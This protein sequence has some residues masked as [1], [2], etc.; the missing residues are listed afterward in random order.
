MSSRL[1]KSRISRPRTALAAARSKAASLWPARKGPNL[2]GISLQTRKVPPF[3]PAQA[4][5]SLGDIDVGKAILRGSFTFGGQTLD[6]GSQGNPWVTAAPSRRHAAW[7]HGFSWLPD[8]L[9]VKGETAENYAA[10]LVDGWIVTYGKGN[11]FA[12][13]LGQ[14][15]PRCY[16]WGAFWSPSLASVGSDSALSARRAAMAQHLSALRTEYRKLEPGLPR[17]QGACALAMGAARSA[18]GGPAPLSRALDRLDL[19]IDAQILPDGG[20]V[21]RSPMAA[22]QALEWLLTLDQ[23]LAA[24]GVEN[25]RTVSRAIDRIA[26]MICV[27]RRADGTLAPFN[28]GG[29]LESDDVS[30]LMDAAPGVPKAFGY[31]PHS[32]FQRL[33]AGESVLLID[34]GS[35]PPRPFD[36]EAHLAPLSIDLSTTDGPIITSCGWTD[37]MPPAWRRPVRSAAAHS[38]LTLDERSPGRL[39][40]P[41]WMRRVVGD[42]VDLDSGPAQAS[43]KEQVS[44]I[45]IEASHGGYRPEYGLAHRRRLFMPANGDDIRGEDCLYVPIGE[46]PIRRDEVDFALRFH[47]HPSVQLSLSQDQSS[48]LLVVGGKAGWRFRT[49]GGPIRIEDSVYLA[50]GHAPVKTQQIVLRGRAFCDSDG[51][52]RTNR[53]RWSFRRLRSK[54]TDTAKTGLH[55]EESE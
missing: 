55:K 28:G 31:G 47:V 27:M 19:E 12:W 20:H 23:I 25:S 26:P 53:V 30:A 39:L 14:L 36:T 32:K 41:D 49:D 35:A 48:A 51:E 11:P 18:D 42:A 29:E 15:V 16:V 22:A 52:S 46:L 34:T 21:S 54:T 13:S 9:S 8:L 5:L 4:K 33:S 1:S 17:L 3:H 6:V 50:K 40:E 45:W 43:R 7:L 38:T 24:R 37:E 44:G 2:G 10:T